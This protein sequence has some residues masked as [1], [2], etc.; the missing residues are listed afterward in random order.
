MD[1]VV[2]ISGKKF[3]ENR[4]ECICGQTSIGDFHRNCNRPWKFRIEFDWKWANWKSFVASQTANETNWKREANRNDEFE[5]QFKNFL[6]RFYCEE[7]ETK[8]KLRSQPFFVV[9][10]S[11]RLAMF[12]LD[13]AFESNRRQKSS[14]KIDCDAI[15]KQFIEKLS[16][17]L[18]AKQQNISPVVDTR[19][20]MISQFVSSKW[21][22][23]LSPHLEKQSIS[24]TSA[25][26][27][28]EHQSGNYL[29]ITI[30][31]FSYFLW[32]LW[33]EFNL[34]STVNFEPTDAIVLLYRHPDKAD[35]NLHELKVD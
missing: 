33:I 18:R 19:W 11:L 13:W 21:K 28:Y 7:N 4:I 23:R 27:N 15:N 8:N 26:R 3:I 22:H 29:G 12:M 35:S 20:F 30:E 31:L 32:K 2:I 34:F 9:L 24:S 6:F 1:S 25:G 17:C 10:Q 5:K 14:P 16:V